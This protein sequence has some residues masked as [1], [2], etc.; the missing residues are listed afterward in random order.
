MTPNLHLLSEYPHHAN[1]RSLSLDRFNVH[2]PLLH[3]TVGLQYQGART[4]D[5]LMTK[6]PSNSKLRLV[7]LEESYTRA[8]VATDYVVS[9]H[10]QVTWTTPELA[11]PSPNYHA[12]GKTFQLSTDLACIAFLHG[13]SL[14]VLGLNS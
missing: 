11:P 5:T 4:H 3:Y 7:E 6:Y 10:G 2:H 8:F 1:Q 9:N 12:N 14:V 13:G